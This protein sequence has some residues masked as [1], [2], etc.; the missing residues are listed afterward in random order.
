V[1]FPW[2]KIKDVAEA[3]DVSTSTVSRVLANKPHVRPE[4]QKHVLKVVNELNIQ[5]QSLNVQE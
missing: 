4:V 2:L 5:Y 1:L 3:A